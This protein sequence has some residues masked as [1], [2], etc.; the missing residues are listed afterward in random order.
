MGALLTST[1]RKDSRTDHWP[2]SE[3][4][5]GPTYEDMSELW[6]TEAVHGSRYTNGDKGNTAQNTK[7]DDNPA[8]A[9]ENDQGYL[10]LHAKASFVDDL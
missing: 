3:G 9:E 1:A 5:V 6:A 2:D 4:S 10:P 8:T 7:D